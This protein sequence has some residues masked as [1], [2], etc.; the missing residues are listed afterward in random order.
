MKGMTRPGS[1]K[2]GEKNGKKDTSRC[3]LIK[4]L[5]VNASFATFPC[6]RIYYTASR[7]YNSSIPTVIVFFC[8]ADCESSLCDY[9]CTVVIITGKV[10]LGVKE[11]IPAI[12]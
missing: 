10:V 1:L 12:L 7:Q 2:K 8:F 6:Y 9:N 11:W 4:E 5:D 3:N